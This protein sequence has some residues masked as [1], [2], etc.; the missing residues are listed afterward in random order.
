[1]NRLVD[2]KA[3]HSRHRVAT[4]AT[5]VALSWLGAHGVGTA[6]S[7]LTFNNVLVYQAGSGT[8]ALN[9]TTGNDVLL[10]EYTPAGTLVQT[11]ALPASGA[12]TK[13]ITAGAA[14]SEG[15]L[16]ISPDGRWVGFS[17][18]NA[19]IGQ[20]GGSLSSSAATSIPRVAGILNATTGTYALTVMGT[21]FNATSPR[22]VASN[23]GNNV[24]AVGG[25]SG[26]VFG[27][28]DGVTPFNRISGTAV[29]T[30]M[31]GLS[32]FGEGANAQLYVS[33]GAN[34]VATVGVYGPSP[35]PTGTATT[36]IAQAN[37]P[38]MPTSPV[39]SRYGFVY[40]DANPAVAGVDTLYVADDSLTSGGVWKYSLDTTGTWL[41][42]GTIQGLNVGLRGMAGLVS[43]TSVRLFTTSSGTM[44]TYWDA[45]AVGSTLS[46]TSTLLTSIAIAATNTAFRGVVVVPEPTAIAMC[47]AGAAGLVMTAAVRRAGRRKRSRQSP[48]GD[49]GNDA[50]KM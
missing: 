13:L 46:G 34:N 20:S 9:S 35:L 19:A 50:A 1:M 10:K 32:V 5:I 44:F 26:L 4:V 41:A 18:Y 15:A 8:N 25:N 48:S 16:S 45:D 29:A 33:S 11:I 12:G 17:G 36:L 27:T 21:W 40:L 43:G 30:N 39:S 28:V 42:R 38:S 49:G 6:Q 22:G 7:P 24:W 37:V 23:D 14:N 2:L 31:R 47:L 3:W